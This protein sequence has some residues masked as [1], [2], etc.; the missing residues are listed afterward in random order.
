[1]L[2]VGAAGAK[3][4]FRSVGVM[5]YKILLALGSGT[6]TSGPS[7]RS[8]DPE[9]LAHAVEITKLSTRADR[10]R[11]LLRRT[12][13]HP[14]RSIADGRTSARTRQPVR[15]PGP[16]A[17]RDR[18]A[19]PRPDHRAPAESGGR[20]ARAGRGHHQL[21]ASGSPH[22]ANTDPVSY[23]RPWQRKTPTSWSPAGLGIQ[24]AI[25][26]AAAEMPQGVR[27]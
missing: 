25:D 20:T 2:A 21:A 15:R 9:S 14:S 13:T 22:R 5:H 18:P 12:S 11:A 4:R 16:R 1:V 27:P 10:R 3:R 8:V 19:A 24:A 7:C 6:G 23:L 17:D 26:V